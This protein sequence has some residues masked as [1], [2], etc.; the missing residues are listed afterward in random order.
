MNKIKKEEIMELINEGRRKTIKDIFDCL[1]CIGSI[2]S[3]FT[4][5][6]FGCYLLPLIPVEEW[7]RFVLALGVLITGL[8]LVV[9]GLWWFFKD[10]EEINKQMKGGENG[11]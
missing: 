11:I 4:Y 2:I 1:V 3:A 9:F 7:M 8:G 6:V 5:M 10:E